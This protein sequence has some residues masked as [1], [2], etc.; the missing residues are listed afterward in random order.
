[1][2]SKEVNTAEARRTRTRL[3]ATAILVARIRIRPVR[4]MPVEPGSTILAMNTPATHTRTNISCRLVG[5][6]LLISAENT[7]IT[8]GSILLYMAI[9]EV[10]A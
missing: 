10:G 4:V 3:I 1:M 2:I 7:S 5:Y 8:M 6:S 9:W